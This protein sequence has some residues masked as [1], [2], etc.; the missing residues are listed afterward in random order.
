MKHFIHAALFVACSHAVPAA[1]RAPDY[2]AALERA[3]ATGQDIVVF[4]RGSDWNPLSERLHTRVWMRP[5][6]AK[7]AGDVV[8]VAVDQPEVVAG[9]AE[10][11]AKRNAKFTWRGVNVPRVALLDREGREVASFDNPRSDLTPAA[12]ASRI[13]DLQKKRLQR[14]ALWTAA[15]KSQGP[16]KAELLRQSLDLLGLGNSTGQNKAY[17][18][19]HKQ[20]KAADPRDTSGAQRWLQ[21]S[22]DPHG[23]PKFITDALKLVGDKKYEDALAA[24]DRELSDPRNRVL[25]HD[26]LQRIML[27]RFQIY[28][29][30]SGH[31]EQRFEEMRKI[32]AL[33]DT[34]YHGIG[35]SGYLNMHF[36]TPVPEF[37]YYG[38]GAQQ[39]KAGTNAWELKV[40][41]ADFLDHAGPYLLHLKHDNGKDSLRIRRVALID[42]GKTVFEATPDVDL[43]PKGKIEIPLI[44]KKWSPGHRV[45]LGLTLEAANG[46]TECAGRIEFEPLLE[47]P[48]PR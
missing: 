21:F 15:E 4:Q 11:L 22:Q 13:H 37:V 42:D 24:I 8:L 45:V 40:T 27:G 25:D 9:P 26:R 2:A 23:V 19:I 32:A 46:K 48:R 34:T 5:D 30:W 36:R 3:K 47:A 18:F 29:Q 17:A 39:V 33:D 10:A 7:A 1:E 12:L 14:D 43:A 6:F 38:W 20:I 44:V 41:A 28:R 35:A 16:E 31:E